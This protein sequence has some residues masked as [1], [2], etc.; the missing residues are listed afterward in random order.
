VQD[1]PSH[2]RLSCKSLAQPILPD[3]S[4]PSAVNFLSVEALH[5]QTA[6]SEIKFQ[7][8]AA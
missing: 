1:E 3:S 6:L 7:R 4:L 2:A 8:R 5:V